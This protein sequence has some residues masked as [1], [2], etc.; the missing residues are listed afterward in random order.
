[1]TSKERVHIALSHREPDRVPVDYWAAPEITHNLQN[2]LS[3]NDYEALLRH[4]NVDFRV[5]PGPRYVGPEFRTL[6][7][8]GTEDIWGVPRKRIPYAYGEG[9]YTHVTVH[10]L[11]GMTT[12]R[13]IDRYM[14]WP[15][16]DGWDYSR[17]AEECARFPGYCVL[18]KGDRLDRTAQLKPAMYLRGVDQILVD[19]A[20]SPGLAEAIIAHISE[21]FL[22]YNRRVFEAADGRIDLF[23]MGDDFGT[24]EGP[25]VGVPM[26]RRF[27]RD[28]FRKYVDLAH[29]YDIKVMHH[30]CGSVVELIPEF[31]DAGLDILQSL[32]P[33]AR[34]M[35]LTALKREY[36]QYICFQGGIDIQRTLP[37]GTAD[38][39]REMA[40]RTLEAGKPGGGY[41]ACTAHNIQPDTPLENVI[42]LFEAYTEYGTYA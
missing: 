19:L 4:L 16:P 8:G 14:H 2:Y 42:A 18:N 1:M 12:A 17:V 22:E 23:M 24:Q 38:D 35:D 13:E 11:A 9:A 6:P 21:Y 34:G 3:L 5:F 30:T 37:F 39:V 15:S 10:P 29:Q 33:R 26:W 31:I 25:M 20:L 27:F 32:Q 7:E 41:I 36:G 40:R 28:N